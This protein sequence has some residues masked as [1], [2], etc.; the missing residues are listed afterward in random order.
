ME[1]ISGT[2][3]FSRG[4][5][6][7]ALS[8]FAYQFLQEQDEKV[9]FQVHNKYKQAIV[10]I[11]WKVLE[12][13]R[14]FWSEERSIAVLGTEREYEYYRYAGT[15]LVGRYNLQIQHGTSIPNDPAARRQAILELYKEGLIEDKS[16]V[17]RLLE[18]GDIVGVF[19]TAKFAKKRQK[20]EIDIM[21]KLGQPV[22]IREYED[23]ASHLQELYAFQQTKDYY[24]LDEPVKMNVDQHTQAHEM[25]MKEL[26]GG[27]PQGAPQPAPP[28][29]TGN[30]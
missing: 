15:S 25:K 22:P 26:Q 16:M 28:P 3:A 30:V 11:Y 18:I 21:T 7:K 8:G 17:L 10:E 20:E 1:H 12:R 9:L 2:R 6:P 24:D 4:E 23:H 27:A 14:Q 29:I 19:D 13:I 5:A